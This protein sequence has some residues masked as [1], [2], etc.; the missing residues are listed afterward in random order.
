MQPNT[1]VPE[2]LSDET[3]ARCEEIIGYQF[4]DRDLLRRCLTH[5][6][7]AK[8]RLDSNERLEF[9][10][11]AILGAVVCEALFNLFASSPEG[12]LTR[13]KS[14]VV[15]RATCA[16]VVKK[17]KLE[18]FLVLGRGISVH[19]RIPG[20][21]LAAAFEALIGGIYL[22]GGYQAAGDF[23]M[24]TVEDEI[25][26]AAESAVGVNH[27]SLLQQRAQRHLGETPVYCVLDERGP[28]H[29]KCFKVAAMVGSRLFPP[30]W[31]SS[32]KTAEQLAAS[33]AI[34]ELDGLTPPHTGD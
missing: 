34:A 3:L 5:A 10:G 8:T 17:L 7:A 26:A 33:N 31:G 20:S 2:D 1:S 24:R 13:I 14:V 19:H 6:S 18:P 23:V 15:S 9:L 28:D 4:R 32:K 21:V 11:D 12:E 16:R 27:K 29:S 22:D 25:S 30:A